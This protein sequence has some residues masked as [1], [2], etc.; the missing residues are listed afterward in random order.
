M[1]PPSMAG[2]IRPDFPGGSEFQL[3]AANRAS[4]LAAKSA[5]GF[6]NLSTALFPWFL[7]VRSSFQFLQDP[8][9]QNELLEKSN[10]RFDPSAIYFDLEGAMPCPSVEP[11]TPARFLNPIVKSHYPSSSQRCFSLT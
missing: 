11:R 10:G 5:R 7:V 8:I 6:A 4:R 9:A 1:V 2:F 3:I